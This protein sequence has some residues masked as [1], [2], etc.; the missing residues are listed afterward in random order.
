MATQVATSASLDR[1]DRQ[2]VHALLIDGRAPF[3]LLAE[4]IGTSEQTVARRYR[5]LQ[6]I[7]AVR[8]LVLPAPSEGALDWIIRID[9]RPG[10]ATKLAAALAQRGDVSWVRIMAGGAEVLCISRPISNE[11]RDALLL[12][13]LARTSVVTSV[14]AHAILKIF[15]GTER[16]FW[17]GFDDPLDGDQ[18]AALMAA[19]PVRRDDSTNGAGH[20][21]SLGRRPEDAALYEVLREDGRAGY[22]QLAAAAEISSARAARRLETLLATG[23]AYVHVDLATDLLGFPTAAALWLSVAPAELERVGER[24]AA[25]SST[26]FIAAVTGPA[27]LTGSVLCRTEAELYSLLTHEIGSIEGIQSAEIS[28]VMRRVK[29][30]G[31]I[32]RGPRLRL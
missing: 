9:V 12:E 14:R 6:D 23:Q 8:V 22:A 20:D 5:R 7:G 28:P 27:N 4:V 15:A 2:L 32:L 1:I 10:A 25:L 3:S 24:L 29:Q 16:D 17:S 18:A 30:A 13:R 19:T 11:Q 26:T 31:T 21:E